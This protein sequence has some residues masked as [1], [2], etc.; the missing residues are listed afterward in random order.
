VRDLVWWCV[1]RGESWNWLWQPY[2][3]VWLFV[4]LV[5]ALLW[6]LSHGVKLSAAAGLVLL[7]LTLDWPVGALGAGYLSSVHTLQY[8]MLSMIIPVL[9]LSGLG[10][11]GASRI[12]ASPRSVAV[13]RRI[14]AP[15]FAAAFFTLVMLATHAPFVL[16][17]LMKSQLGSFSLDMLWLTSGVLLAW[18]LVV[19]VPERPRFGPPL[20]ILYVFAGTVAHVFV[21]MWFLTTK[22]PVYATYELAPRIEGLTAMSDQ[23]LAGA[24]I[25]LIGTPVVL[26]AVTYIFFSWQGTGEERD[27]GRWQLAAG[28]RDAPRANQ[29]QTANGGSNVV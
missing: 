21:G 9:L 19:P 8:V 23:H 5:A 3:G 7:W 17:Y 13:L 29:Q 22:F 20:R 27:D 4:A 1:A 11:T 12:A 24:V 26:G 25:L 18:P 2:P 28:G 10:H 14:T 15:P 16:D 6:R